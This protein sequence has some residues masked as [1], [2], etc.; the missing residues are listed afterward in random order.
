MLAQALVLARPELVRS[1]TL[2]GT[3]C[4]FAQAVREGMRERAKLARQQGMAALVES[5]LARWFTPATHARRPDVIDRITKTL[6]VDNPLIHAAV[7]D[8]ISHF[9]TQ[10]RL[11]EI[12]CPTLIL[13]G[14]QDPSTSPAAA[15]IVQQGITGSQL[16]VLPL[17][18]HMVQMGSTGSRQRRASRLP[19]PR[20]RPR[21]DPII[22]A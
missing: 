14:E 15:G 9:D 19:R 8:A 20:K 11:N 17:A 5:S 22:R 13:V 21:P 4:T 6:L 18:S 10:P 7:W 3:A 1:L 16:V 2:M 12:L